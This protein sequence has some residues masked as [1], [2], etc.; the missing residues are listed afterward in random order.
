MRSLFPGYYPPDIPVE[1]F[2]HEG[3]VVFDANVLLNAYRYSDPAKEKLFQAIGA[4]GQRA[5]LP[6]QAALEFQRNRLSVVRD[7]QE[8]YASAR[9]AIEKSRDEIQ[10]MPNVD[11]EGSSI[12]DD[13]KKALEDAGLNEG[14]KKLLNFIQECESKLQVPDLNDETRV[15]IDSLFEGKVGGEP[16]P[17]QMEK[18]RAEATRRIEKRIPPGFMDAKKGETRS[19]G[20]ALVWLQVLEYVKGKNK[21]VVFVSDDLKEDWYWIVGSKK[22]GP[23]PELV[24]EMRREAN[25]DVIFCDSSRFIK[26]AWELLLSPQGKST[27]PDDLKAVLEEAQTVQKQNLR[28]EEWQASGLDGSISNLM[29]RY[30]KQLRTREVNGVNQDRIWASDDMFRGAS[31][32]VFKREWNSIRQLSNNDISKARR[33]LLLLKQIGAFFSSSEDDTEDFIRQVM[34][35]EDELKH[36]E[37]TSLNSDEEMAT[38]LFLNRYMEDK[39]PDALAR[40]E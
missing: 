9:T 36:L 17:E 21:P 39:I 40:I 30:L 6:Y 5:F 14:F 20:D 18:W 8:K 16:S 35:Y 28:E 34:S 22:I 1:N 19:H 2:W 37:Q 38:L 23:R 12:R 32:S 25:V 29:Q 24:E 15:R 11:K 10:K 13:L 4:V 31:I 3:I 7:R 26:Q 27:D 33:S